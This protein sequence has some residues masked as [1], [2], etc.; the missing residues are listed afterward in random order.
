MLRK[1]LISVTL[2]LSLIANIQ[3]TKKNDSEI[4]VGE[5]GSLT[6]SEAT[7]GVSTN[8]GIKLA[9]D[10]INASG[11]VNGKKIKLITLDDQGKA[12]EAAQA[13]TRLITQDKVAAIIGEVASTRSLAA[14]PIAQQYKI[15]MI[16]PSSTNPKVTEIGDYIFR[17]CFIDP[18]QGTVMAKFALENL[19]LKKLAIL[20][21]VK[22]DYSMGLADFFAAK[23]KEM[24]GEIVSDVSYAS[25]DNNFKAQLTKMK[26][27]NPEGIF[28]PGYY[29]E[30]GLIAKQAKE[31]GMNMPLLGGD[32]WDSAKLSEIGGEAINGNY[33]SNHY[34]TESQDQTV[35][36]FISKFKAKYNETPDGLAALGYDAARI[37]TEAM[38]K[39]KEPTGP[40][41]RDELAKIA[42][43]QGVTGKITIDE[44][45]N[46]VK[47][48]VVVKVEGKDNKFVTTITP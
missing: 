48:A 30:V 13:V 18:F 16:S 40:L 46:A 11:G 34:T 22:S 15:P 4:L 28:I 27:S 12:E 10:E 6:G 21:D 29:T 43:F 44:K 26:S 17:V 42:G 39:A 14:A 37:L 45:R 2:T 41:V 23:V 5:F 9:F 35:V 32:G 1:I 19:K 38:K 24:G 20:R 7:F 3:C 31:L 36:E 47:S 25:G 33:F 8:K